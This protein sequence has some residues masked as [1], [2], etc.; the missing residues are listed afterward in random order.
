MLIETPYKTGDTVSLKLSSGEE[1]VARL[2]EESD[3][4]YVLHKPLMLANT[5]QGIG[6]APFMFT[7]SQDAKIK[8]NN[9]NVLTIVKTADE[10]AKQYVESTTGLVT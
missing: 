6:L 4:T 9:K 8:I 7:V 10:F 1:L 3:T 2:E 5:P